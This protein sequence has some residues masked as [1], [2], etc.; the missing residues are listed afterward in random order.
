MIS[1]V[2]F[3]GVLLVCFVWSYLLVVNEKLVSCFPL[4]G[5]LI[6]YGWF[7]HTPMLGWFWENVYTLGWFLLSYLPLG[8]VWAVFK[9]FWFVL[10]ERSKV[11]SALRDYREWFNKNRKR[12]EEQYA[13]ARK[14][15]TEEVH[16]LQEDWNTTLEG[17]VVKAREEL[18]KYTWSAYLENRGGLEPPKFL[19]H[20]K[21]FTVWWLYWPF[22]L[23]H[24]AVHDSVVALTHT[25]SMRIAFCLQGISNRMYKD[26]DK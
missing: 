24:F 19:N 1:G 15:M 8:F 6:G 9:W 11:K 7:Y 17:D 18:N 22:S 16:P 3:Y 23:L 4:V 5:A 14:R 10:G 25:V 12:L 20:K 2:I 13:E 26:I 21:N